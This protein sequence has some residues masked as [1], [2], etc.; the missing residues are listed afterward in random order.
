M[1]SKPK[2][3]FT[4]LSLTTRLISQRALVSPL[5]ISLNIY[6]KL[7][8]VYSN[9]KLKSFSELKSEFDV[10]KWT[11]TVKSYKH[12][13]KGHLNWNTWKPTVSQTKVQN[14]YI[15]VFFIISWYQLDLKKRR[16]LRNS[17]VLLGVNRLWHVAQWVS[18]APPHHT[19]PAF[20]NLSGR[21]SSSDR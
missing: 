17:L 20:L 1:N 9:A 7:T 15:K 4:L 11:L 14:F 5:N 21:I 2:N 13:F 12:F 18:R 6:F 3:N 19:L 8:F 16:D 10:R